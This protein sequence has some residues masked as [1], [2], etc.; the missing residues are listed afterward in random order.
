M[1]PNSPYLYT[2]HSLNFALIILKI[3]IIF[4]Y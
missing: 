1:Y 3:E 4:Y 2:L